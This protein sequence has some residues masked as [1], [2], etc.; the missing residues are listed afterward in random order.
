MNFPTV[1]FTIKMFAT[2]EKF[3]HMLLRVKMTD[4]LNL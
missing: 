1:V 3:F 2:Y 4:T